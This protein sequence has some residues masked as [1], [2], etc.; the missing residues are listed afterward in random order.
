[1]QSF[2]TLSPY[3]H[4]GILYIIFTIPMREYIHIQNFTVKRKDKR[5]MNNT[6]LQTSTFDFY[7]DELIALRDNATGEIYTAIT[8]VLRGIGFTD[9]QISHQQ[10]KM[11]N[12]EILKTHTLKF[13]GVDLNMPSVNEIW[14]ISQRKLPLAL[15]KI[16]ITPAMKRNQPELSKRLIKYQDK[17]ADVLASVFID[18]QTTSTLDTKLLAE[19]ISTVI[20]TALQ[21]INE[22]LYQLEYSQ[23]NRYLL[24]NK[25]PSAWYRK[26]AP[27][28]KML[29]E[30]F[31]CT[32]SELYSSIYKELEDTYNVDINQ[33]HEDYCYENHLLKNECYAMDAIEHNKQLKDAITFLIDN[34]LVKYGLQTKEQLKNSKRK[35]L[36]DTEPNNN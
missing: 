21:P 12:D 15:A 22:R 31:G 20:T 35:T 33:I 18:N 29:M 36:F 14:C 10:N 8:H 2:I 11:L 19:T 34:S 9:K 3:S 30:Y 25:Y 7:G 24:E 6:A 1:M 26:I 17:C 27:K 23:K 5:I 16:N 4:W 28:Y 13:S 32:R